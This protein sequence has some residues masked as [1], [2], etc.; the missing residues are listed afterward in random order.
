MNRIDYEGDEGQQPGYDPQ[1]VKDDAVGYADVYEAEEDL[2]RRWSRERLS[3]RWT[4]TG[5]SGQ[6]AALETSLRLL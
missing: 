4:L 1:D 6:G 2:S 5:L 3:G